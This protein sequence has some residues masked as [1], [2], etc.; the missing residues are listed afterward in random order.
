MLNK[1]IYRASI[2]ETFKKNI[3]AGLCQLWYLNGLAEGLIVYF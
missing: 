2:K 1:F 3:T